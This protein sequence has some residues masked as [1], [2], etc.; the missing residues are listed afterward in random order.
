VRA[1]VDVDGLAGDVA[2][3]VAVRLTAAGHARIERTVRQLLD[4]EVDLIGALGAEERA[5]LTGFLA[6]LERSLT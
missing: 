6:K 4:H 2:R 5:A 3:A 1:A